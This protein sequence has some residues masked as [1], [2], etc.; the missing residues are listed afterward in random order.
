M[1]L[2]QLDDPWNFVRRLELFPSPGFLSRRDMNYAVEKRHKTIPSFHLRIEPRQ[3][4][5]N[6]LS[7]ATS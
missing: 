3:W 4:R 5:A 2:L 6:K 7:V 1:V